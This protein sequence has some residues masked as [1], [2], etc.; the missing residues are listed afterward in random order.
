MKLTTDDRN[1]LDLI[2]QEIEAAEGYLRSLMFIPGEALD[3]SLRG[4]ALETLALAADNLS[5]FLATH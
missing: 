5:L 1:I 2:L 4:L 3:P